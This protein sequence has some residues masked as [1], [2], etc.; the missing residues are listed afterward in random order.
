VPSSSY[1]AKPNLNPRDAI[2][3]HVRWKITLLLAT[4]MHEPLSDR[5][6]RSI[7]H[8]EE[9]SIGRWLHSEHTLPLRSTPEYRAVVDLHLAFH[10]IM[11]HIGGLIN[12]GEFDQ[13]EYLL[14]SPEP[15]QN[16]SNAFAN[17]LMA[18]DGCTPSGSAH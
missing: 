3:S 6:T 1:T 10:D 4:R 12:A 18:L 5:A 7:H 8:P 11:Q 14:N 16:A 9:C 2:A 13:A 15:F 17:A